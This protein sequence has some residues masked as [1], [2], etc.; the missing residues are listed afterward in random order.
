[1]CQISNTI[2][3]CTCKVKSTDSLQNYWAVYRRNK[4]KNI[5]I[6]GEVML[7]SEWIEPNYKK[8]YT[9]LKNRINETDPFDIPI[10]FKVGD[11]LEI[12]FNNNDY[13]KR[14]VYGFKYST[15]E[16]ITNKNDAFELMGK[17]DKIHFGKIKKNQ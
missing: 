16:W 5:I 14:V 17:F 11:F 15:S 1:M 3:F 6:V 13:D 12:V 10:N 9:V 7:P 2:K 8:N 4:A